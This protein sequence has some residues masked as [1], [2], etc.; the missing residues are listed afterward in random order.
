MGQG[1][2]PSTEL[3]KSSKNSWGSKCGGRFTGLW[4]LVYPGEL[5]YS[6]GHDLE[7]TRWRVPGKR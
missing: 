7:G 4:G 2:A 3:S 1:S 5:W 6:I